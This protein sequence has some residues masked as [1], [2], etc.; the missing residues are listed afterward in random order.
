MSQLRVKSIC[1]PNPFQKSLVSIVIQL[2][3]AWTDQCRDFGRCFAKLIFL[4]HIQRV[5]S[6]CQCVQAGLAQSVDAIHQF[7]GKVI[8]LIV[9]QTFSRTVLLSSRHMASVPVRFICSQQLLQFIGTHCFFFLS[10]FEIFIDER[11]YGTMVKSSLLH[12]V[13]LCSIL[14]EWVHALNWEL[15]CCRYY[16]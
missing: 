9:I 6:Y 5:G 11:V 8:S 16:A 3:A 10:P 15:D 2:L 4:S 7:A 14:H 13:I 12:R 1:W